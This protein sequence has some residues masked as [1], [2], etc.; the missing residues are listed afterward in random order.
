MTINFVVVAVFFVI[1]THCFTAVS[2]V[3]SVSCAVK[4]FMC[5]VGVNFIFLL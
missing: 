4:Y 3:S 1:L 2:V 5:Y